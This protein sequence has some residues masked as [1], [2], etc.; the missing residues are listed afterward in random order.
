MNSYTVDWK[1][2]ILDDLT[3]I[4]MNA[5][6]RNAVTRSQDSIDKLLKQNPHGVGTDLHEGLRKLHV[7]PLEVLFSI[8][9]AINIVEVEAVNYRP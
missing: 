7:P 6:E 8:D 1:D 2:E 5:K 4:W 3:I 9:D